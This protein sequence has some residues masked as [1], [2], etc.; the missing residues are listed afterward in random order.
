[1][2]QFTLQFT[3]QER[4]TRIMDHEHHL[5]AL[6]SIW[7]RRRCLALPCLAGRSLSVRTTPMVYCYRT[8]SE[9]GEF[10][11]LKSSVGK[12]KILASY[13]RLTMYLLR[14][15][16]H[17]RMRPKRQHSV[18]ATAA[19]NLQCT[20]RSAEWQNGEGLGT[21]ISVGEV[22]CRECFIMNR[23]RILVARTR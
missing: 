5:Y 2:T 4:R 18:H 8:N 20:S 6:T 1:M 15:C 3:Q 9:Y 11:A 21:S 13:H 10:T 23:G 12:T 16:E 22:V 14:T 19:I 17:Y 7:C